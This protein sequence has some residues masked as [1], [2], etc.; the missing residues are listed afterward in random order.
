MTDIVNR[1]HE[2]ILVVDDNEPVLGLVAAILEH[3]NFRVLSACD[4]TSAIQVANDVEGKI[5]L[6][7]T[8]VD[9]PRMSGPDLGELLKKTR[10]DLH[11]MLMSGGAI[12]NFLALNYGWAFI[13]KPFL[14]GKLVQMVT[15]LLHAP[16]RSQKGGQEFDSRK[17]T[18]RHNGP[19]ALIE[20]P[21]FENVEF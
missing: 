10:P 2:T 8:D 13:R 20:Y 19:I 12:G 15:E 7:L 11:V 16:G 17:D 21:A 4:G 5:D 18:N 14:A 9:M 6:L 3:A 1:E